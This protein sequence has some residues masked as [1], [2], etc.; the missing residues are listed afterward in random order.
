[1]KKQE[2]LVTSNNTGTA[3]DQNISN[4]YSLKVGVCE[5]NFFEIGDR[6]FLRRVING[7]NEIT[8]F[9]VCQGTHRYTKLVKTCK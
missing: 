1:M 6:I 5:Y 7:T 9:P 3:S 2:I 4:S 8:N